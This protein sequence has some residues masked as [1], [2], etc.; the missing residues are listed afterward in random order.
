MVVDRKIAV[1]NSNNIQDRPNLE[2]SCA[3]LLCPSRLTDRIRN[4]QMMIHLEGHIV[5]SIYDNILI[6]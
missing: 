1:L 3:I 4:F 2:V 6:S 5:D